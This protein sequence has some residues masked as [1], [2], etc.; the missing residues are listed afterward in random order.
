LKVTIRDYDRIN[1]INV[2]DGIEIGSIPKDV[3]LERVRWDGKKL[4]DLFKLSKMWV[5]YKNGIFLLHCIQV[6]HS[7]LVEMQ[8]K[9]RKKLWNDNGIYKIKTEKE[10]K[11]EETIQYRKSH[12]PEISD[13]IG[14]VMKYLETKSD[15]STE[16]QELIN[17]INTIKEQY[18]KS[19]T[20]MM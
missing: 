8:Y 18:P 5:E 6:P 7:Q 19:I 2:S 15:L 13:Q 9:D 3:G 16:L 1:K 14:A 11:A 12:Y 4:V 10:I 17:E 20:K